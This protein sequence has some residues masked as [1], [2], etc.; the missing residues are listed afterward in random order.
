MTTQVQ[1]RDDWSVTVA[2]QE[3]RWVGLAS[4]FSRVPGLQPAAP[5]VEQPTA[6]KTKSSALYKIIGLQWDIMEA[7]FQ[8]YRIVSKDL[9]PL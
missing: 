8:V 1:D 2:E 3:R 7:F 9:V 6:A 5:T 4:R